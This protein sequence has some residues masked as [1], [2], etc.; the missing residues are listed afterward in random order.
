MSRVGVHPRSPLRLYVDRLKD[1]GYSLTRVT[2]R[3]T[4]LFIAFDSIGY[5]Y[6]YTR[7]FQDPVVFGR[8]LTSKRLSIDTSWCWSWDLSL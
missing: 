8:L 6:I 1:P 2:V 3:Q 5:I 7:T 4:I